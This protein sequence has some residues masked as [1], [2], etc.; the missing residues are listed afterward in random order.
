LSRWRRIL[1]NYL[2]KATLRQQG[3]PEQYGE[4]A[5][6]D[7]RGALSPG[8]MRRY[9]TDLAA[10]KPPKAIDSPL[11]IV[12]GEKEMKAAFSFARGYMKLYPA[13][14]GAVE[15]NVTHAWCLQKPDLFASM[16]RSWMRNQPPPEG[17]LP[18][19]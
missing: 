4:L 10:W 16:V 9:M 8:F 13:A 18:L 5:S 3:I 2:V 11:L 17:L 1:R 15:K 6:D 12:V 7:L 19:E 14:R